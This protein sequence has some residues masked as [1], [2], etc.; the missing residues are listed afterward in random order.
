MPPGG[1]GNRK[2][3]G[4]LYQGGQRETPLWYR[5]R[6]D[7]PFPTP[8]RSQGLARVRR[9]VGWRGGELRRRAAISEAVYDATGHR[10]MTITLTPGAH[11]RRRPGRSL[12]RV[13]PLVDGLAVRADGALSILDSL[14]GHHYHPYLSPLLPA[15]SGWHSVI[16]DGPG[17]L[18][19]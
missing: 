8:R 17:Q 13:A 6:V 7:F 3:I 5:T 12:N 16:T 11:I 9:Q 19:P 4:V 14:N 10:I 2:S 18:R 1:W 15:P